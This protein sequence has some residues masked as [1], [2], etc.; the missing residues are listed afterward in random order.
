MSI[1][2][3]DPIVSYYHEY[4]I[5]LKLIPSGGQ[6]VLD[7]QQLMKRAD[8]KKLR[9]LAEQHHLLTKLDALISTQKKLKQ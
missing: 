2:K 6:D 1:V 7:I 5:L 3:P 9:T 8:K 4:L